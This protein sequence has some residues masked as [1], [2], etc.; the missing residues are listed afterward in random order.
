MMAEQPL[1]ELH[2]IKP[3]DYSGSLH[4]SSC[5]QKHDRAGPHN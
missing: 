5:L 1:G 2:Q 4:N 3:I